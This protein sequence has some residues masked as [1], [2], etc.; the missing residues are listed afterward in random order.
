MGIFETHQKVISFSIIVIFVLGIVQYINFSYVQENGKSLSISSKFQ[1]IEFS[2]DF[3]VKENLTSLN[4]DLLSPN[5]T[6]TEIG[7]N[8][9][10]IKMGSE[11]VIIEDGGDSFK[12][13]NNEKQCRAV[14]INI[15]QPTIILAVEIY[16][17]VNNPQDEQM[18]VHINGYDSGT[19]K[20]NSTIYGSPAPLNMS[21]VPNWYK[22]TFSSPISLTIGYYYL[23]VNGTDIGDDKTPKYYWYNNDINP[24]YPNLY[25]WDWDGSWGGGSIDK[26]LRY[27]IDRRVERGYSPEEINMTAEI[28]GNSYNVTDGAEIGTGILSISNFDFSPPGVNFNILIKHNLSIELLLS[29]SYHLSLKHLFTSQGSAL[30]REYLDNKWIINPNFMRKYSN[31]YIKFYYPKSWHNFTILK[32]GFDI[33]SDV[34]NNTIDNYILFPN[35]TITDGAT[36]LIYANSPNIDFSLNAPI[37]QYEPNELLYFYIEP[38]IM[39]GNLS[40]YLIDNT[41]LEVGK[42]FLEISETTSSNLIYTNHLSS[43]P[44]EGLYRAYVFWYNNTDAGVKTQEFSVDVPFILPPELIFNIILIGTIILI[45]SISGYISVKRLR[46]IRNG[47]RQK[48]FNK[49]MDILNLKYFIVSEKNSGLNVYEQLFTGKNLESSLISGFLQAIRAFGI[50]ITDAD[51]ESRSIKLDYQNSKILMSDYKNSRLIFLME[52]NP[53][54]DFL[55]SITALSHDIEENYGKLLENFNGDIAPLQGIKGLLEQ[56]LHTSLIY[57]LKVISQNKG[58]KS[59]E[60]TM[61]SRALEIMKEK[62]TDYFFVSFLLGKKKGFQVRDAETI[63][64]LIHKNIFKPIM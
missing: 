41:G 6:I 24:L 8:F 32:N 19:D 60:K 29:F 23:V 31:Y 35:S 9:T 38:P 54:R 46:R 1:M 10:S 37:T 21:T 20:P 14:Q 57:P 26:C 59:Y 33:T 45:V 28:N 44:N 2:D 34:I 12:T 63:F 42:E 55:D 47:H 5:W 61:I 62:N 48:I 39:S 36:W 25:I 51:E 17:Y 13:V 4:I 56:H 58:I 16:G 50:E 18:L 15:T 49:Y 7:I 53:S 43:N 64:N 27:K 3:G 22:Q 52:E 11:I 40:V 30:I